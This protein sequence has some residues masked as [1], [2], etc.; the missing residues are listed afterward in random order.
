MARPKTCPQPVSQSRVPLSAV[1]IAL[2]AA[3]VIG[4]CLESLAFAEEILVVDS[5]SKD[6]TVALAEAAGARVIQQAWLGFGPQK[7]FAVNAAKHDWVLCVDT[8]ERVTPELAASIRSFIAAPTSRAAAAPRRNRFMGRWLAHGEGYPDWSLRLFDRR[9][10][11][12]SDDAVHEKVLTDESVTRLSGDLR[13]ESAEDVAS[14]IA[15]QNRYTSLQAAT[16]FD[17]GK[18]VGALQVVASPLLRFL[19]FYLFRMGF[20]DGLPGFAHIVIGSFA[21]FLKYAKL[22][23]LNRTQRPV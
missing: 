17:A 6:L 22:Y 20:L 14:Y 2:D 7:Q 4:P 11:R 12:W 9:A 8:D 21:S 1:I 10:A 19:K 13:H 18:R 23:E 15:K 5:G 3:A 16:S